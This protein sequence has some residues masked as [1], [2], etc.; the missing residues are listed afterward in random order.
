MFDLNAAR[1]D[2]ATTLEAA[3]IKSTLDP[4]NVSAPI[5]VVGLPVLTE[6]TG[7]CVVNVDIEV[8]AVAPAPGNLDAIEWLLDTV[9]ALIDL[10]P[11]SLASPTSFEVT[12]G[13][14]LPAYTLVVSTQVKEI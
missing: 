1:Q 7:A 11:F 14:P 5:T 6:W 10:F 4:R 3:G 2:L 8:T 9:A 12:Q 13:Q